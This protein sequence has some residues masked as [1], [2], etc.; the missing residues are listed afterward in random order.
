[1]MAKIFVS[2]IVVLM[3]CASISYAIQ[4]DWRQSIFWLCASVINIVVTDWRIEEMW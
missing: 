1:M 4:N 2:I 3:I